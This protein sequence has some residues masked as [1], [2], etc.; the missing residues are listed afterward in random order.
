M[1][2][3]W[4]RYRQLIQD[5]YVAYRFEQAEQVASRPLDAKV[6]AAAEPLMARFT[7]LGPRMQA[8][9]DEALYGDVEQ[10]LRDHEAL[11][12]GQCAPGSRDWEDLQYRCNQLMALLASIAL[13]QGHAGQA[14]QWFDRAAEGWQALGNQASADECRQGALEA[15]LADGADV[16]TVMGELESSFG[17]RAPARKAALHVS[18]ARAL[19]EAGDQA[20]ARRQVAAAERLLNAIG[21]TDP[22]AAGS[23][24][25]AFT[26]W[27]NSGHREQM[28]AVPWLQVQGLLN[29]VAQT[30]AKLIGMRFLLGIMPLAEAQPLVDEL[31]V[32]V[33][34]LISEG[35]EAD[36]EARAA[37]GWTDAR[38]GCPARRRQRRVTP[39]HP[40]ERRARPPAP[41]AAPR[42]GATRP[43][44]RRNG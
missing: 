6:R 2:Q 44:G 18:S 37:A 4:E 29:S 9:G 28:S 27:L 17:G 25:D 36:R 11:R 20:G 1:S 12:D 24:E 42:G 38:P 8:G 32:L 7:A 34:S 14:R 39:L 19:L 41:R 35:V 13:S 26:A 30:W 23:A 21:F 22:V 5:D 40:A 15:A 16:D 33:R 10:L 31:W 43:A 3:S